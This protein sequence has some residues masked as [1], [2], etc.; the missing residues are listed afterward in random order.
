V[1]KLNSIEGNILR[2]VNVDMIDGTPL[3]DIKPYVRDLDSEDDIRVGWLEG[4]SKR[5]NSRVSGNRSFKN[6]SG[7]EDE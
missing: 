4:R 7:G 6:K 3:L 1:V 5:K 2:I